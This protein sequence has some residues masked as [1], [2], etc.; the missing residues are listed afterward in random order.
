MNSSPL[1][2]LHVLL[3]ELLGLIL[4]VVRR[5]GDLVPR[6]IQLLSPDR[7]LPRRVP[8]HPVEHEAGH[9][10]EAA[11]GDEA[12]QDQEHG[13]RRRYEHG[14]EQDQHRGGQHEA[15]D[16]GGEGEAGEDHEGAAEGDGGGGLRHLVGELLLVMKVVAGL[17][18]GHVDRGVRLERDSGEGFGDER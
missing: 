8:I 6:T 3:S 7:V 17:D 9:G 1:P 11:G 16:G 18:V 10:A 12:G 13:D 5:V 15:D 14:A 2:A 4:D